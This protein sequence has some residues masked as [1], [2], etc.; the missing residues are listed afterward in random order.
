MD[1][2]RIENLFIQVKKIVTQISSENLKSSKIDLVKEKNKLDFVT[3]LDISMENSLKSRLIKLLPGSK[4]FG[5]EENQIHTLDGFTWVVDPIDGTQNFIN[6][7]PFF[8]SSVALYENIKPLFS[9]VCS[10]STNNTFSSIFGFGSFLND[11]K[12]MPKK[13]RSFLCSIST[14]ML[15]E[16]FSNFLGI[17]K[18]KFKIRIFGCQAMSLCYTAGG[19]FDLNI[20]P[21]AMFWDDA[22]AILILKEAGGDY[23][24]KQSDDLIKKVDSISLSRNLDEEFKESILSEWR[25]I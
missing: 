20:N 16:R 13:D 8:C 3:N 12:L 22:A 4:F 9:I 1:E 24:S 5:E 6:D 10:P 21:D 17:L 7:I 23:F 25:K 19:Y 11:K 2:H 14:C 18:S 15:D